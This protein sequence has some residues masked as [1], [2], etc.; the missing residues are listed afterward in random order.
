MQ[1]NED[2]PDDVRNATP[3]EEEIKSGQIEE[4]S[5]PPAV[6][7][8]PG[9]RNSRQPPS[10]DPKPRKNPDKKQ[11][12]HCAKKLKKKIK[13]SNGPA[14]VKVLVNNKPCTLPKLK[15]VSRHCLSKKEWM[16]LLA[17]PSRKCPPCRKREIELKLRPISPRINELALPTKQRMMTTLQDRSEVLPADLVDKLINL[18]E[19]ETCLTPEYVIVNNDCYVHTE[20]FGENT[21]GILIIVICNLNTLNDYIIVWIF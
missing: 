2:Q 11:K 9:N 14:T 12:E 8:G 16:N 21:G 4:Q 18:L 5:T 7:D 19:G 15:S 20:F 13:D 17:A 3:V 10:A 6:E 1:S